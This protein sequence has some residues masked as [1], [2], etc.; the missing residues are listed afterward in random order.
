MKQDLLYL[1]K[2]FSK[3]F[4]AVRAGGQTNRNYVVEFGKKKF[5]VR[6]PWEGVID[7]D[8][9][10][11]NVARIAQNQKLKAILPKYFLYILR[12]SNILNPKD[13]RTFSVPDGTTVAEYIAG[14]EF[15]IAMFREKK[16]QQALA[17]MFYTFHTSGVRFVNPYNVFR[18][19]IDK[20]RLTAKKLSLAR[21]VSANR[22][23]LLEQ[24][25]KEAEKKLLSLTKGTPTHNDFLF[26]NF[27]LGKDKK[28]YLLDFEYAGLNKKGGIF[29]DFGFLFADNLFRKPTVTKELFERFLVVADG[30]YKKKLDREQIYWAAVAATLVQIWWGVLRYFSVPDIEKPYFRDYTETRIRGISEVAKILKKRELVS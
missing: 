4:R 27:L 13:K 18:D 20:Y 2:L 9:E 3:P 15:N 16:Y 17:K 23:T 26:Q 14:K 25:E 28:V 7:R 5:F 21:L 19:E 1:K 10:G 12:K 29:Y 6:L 8:V 30:V 11:A 22:V 24:I